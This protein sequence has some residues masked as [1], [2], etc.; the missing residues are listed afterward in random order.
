MLKTFDE[1]S[2]ARSFLFVPGNRPDRFLKAC[3]SGA[4]EVIVDLEDAVPPADKLAAREIV[5]AWLNSEHPVIV[6]IN[7]VNTAWFAG[8]AALCRKPGV[9]AVILPKTEGVE[10][11]R[12]LEEQ[13]GG[14]VPILPLIETANGFSNS[15]AIAQDTA[16]RR[17]IFGALDFQLDLGIHGNTHELLYF[18]SQLVLFS[19]LAGIAPPV[20]GI[21]TEIDDAEP[22]RAATLRSR[23]LGFGGKLCIHPKQV[24][25]VNECFRPTPEE[26]EWAR[27][28]IEAAE[29]SKGAAVRA[30]GEM[31]DT[32]VMLRAAR[33]LREA[34]TSPAD[35]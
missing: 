23:R 18:R 29:A 28:V 21:N 17:L 2:P 9:R 22:L 3:A 7:A 1:P 25:H 11:L 14:P 5:D 32:P 33:I 35:A 34:E 8:D 10:H 24:S 30:A 20:D 31:V 16:V 4:H 6:R 15:L 26:I 27:R 19:R 13:A 12:A